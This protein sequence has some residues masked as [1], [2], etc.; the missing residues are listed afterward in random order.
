[1]NRNGYVPLPFFKA[2]SSWF[3]FKKGGHCGV[4]DTLCYCCVCNYQGERG[5]FGFRQ[6]VQIV[7]AIMELINSH[8]EKKGGR[9]AEEFL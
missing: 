2:S 5:G 6:N 7:R 9:G 1:M 8:G 3:C 4:N